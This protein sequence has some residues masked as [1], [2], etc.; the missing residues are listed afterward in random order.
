MAVRAGIVLLVVIMGGF[1]ALGIGAGTITVCPSGCDYARIQDAINAAN[2][3]DTISIGLGEYVETLS[4]FKSVSLKG[5]GQD[6]VKLRGGAFISGEGITVEVEGLT[7]FG[8]TGIT[9]LGAPIL[10]SLIHI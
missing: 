2:P 5:A 7:I 10:L 1:G 6:Q 9:A 4:I 8:G 3:G